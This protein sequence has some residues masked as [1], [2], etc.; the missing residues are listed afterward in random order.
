MSGQGFWTVRL[1]THQAFELLQS[2][3]GFGFEGVK[4]REEQ[5]MIRMQKQD[6]RLS[7]KRCTV[8]DWVTVLSC[9]TIKTCQVESD[10]HSCTCV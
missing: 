5:D 4:L 6:F 8:G 9:W 2:S 1:G 10:A 7:G 3:Y